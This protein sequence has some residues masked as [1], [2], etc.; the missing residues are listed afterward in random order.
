M[1][2]NDFRWA[3]RLTNDARVLEPRQEGDR[4]L[5]TFCVAQSMPWRNG[6]SG[7][8]EEKSQFINVAYRS[9][10]RNAS[11][12]RERLIKGQYV[13]VDGELLI[14]HKKDGPNGPVTYVTINATKIQFPPVQ[15]VNPKE[16]E[17]QAPEPPASA[18]QAHPDVFNP[19]RFADDPE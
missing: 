12:L 18:A 7:T 2:I 8:N 13:L 4:Y 5:F 19:A 1:Y 11:K 6:T 9:S 3:G 10:E 15:Y 14:E 17:K 16:P